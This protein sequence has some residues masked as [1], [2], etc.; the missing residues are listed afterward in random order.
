MQ[1]WMTNEISKLEAKY[2]TV[3]PPWIIYNEH[4][5]SICWRMGG[6]E[7]H[8]ELWWEWWENQ[9]FTETQ[10]TDYFRKWKPPYCWLAFLIEAIWE[11]DVIEED[12]LAPYFALTNRLGFGSQADYEK[13]LEDPK[14]L[15][16]YY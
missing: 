4:P 2:N 8:I 11:I 13:D 12:K 10:K 7:S 1:E 15:E 5:Y 14:W 6:G 3:P 16:K 9:N